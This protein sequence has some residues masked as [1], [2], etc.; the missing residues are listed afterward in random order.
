[1]YIKKKIWSFFFTSKNFKLICYHLKAF[2]NKKLCKIKLTKFVFFFN[3]IKISDFFMT[4]YIDFQLFLTF[5]IFICFPDFYDLMEPCIRTNVNLITIKKL[6]IKFKILFCKNL[7]Q[8]LWYWHWR[9]GHFT[10]HSF[11][12][13]GHHFL[14]L[15]IVFRLFNFTLRAVRCQSPSYT[16]T[17]DI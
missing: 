13:S 6:K 1:M 2:E 7:T 3:F 11:L 14:N 16:H 15:K 9:A 4:F 12:S 8:T 10:G 17:I 5:T